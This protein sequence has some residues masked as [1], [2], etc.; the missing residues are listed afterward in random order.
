MATDLSEVTID[1]PDGST[2]V[3]KGNIVVQSKQSPAWLVSGVGQSLN[4]VRRFVDGGGQ[5]GRADS[6][7]QGLYF[8]TGGGVRVHEIGFDQWEGN[9]D[10]WGD[11]SASDGPV[12]KL[13]ELDHK[14]ASVRIDSTRPAT[15]SFAEF[16]PTGR[17]DPLS[18]VPDDVS[19]IFDGQE[20]ASSFRTSVQLA[21]SMDLRETIEQAG[22]AANDFVLN[23][24]IDGAKAA[25][26]LP[27]P[28][29]ATDQL[30]FEQ[31]RRTVDA[32]VVNDGLP[33]SLP[34]A[35]EPGERL[36]T[37]VYRGD[38]ASELEGLLRQGVLEKDGAD[39]VVLEAVGNSFTEFTDEYVLKGGSVERVHPATDKAFQVALRLG[40]YEDPRP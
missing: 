26:D 16:S 30:S 1:L 2:F 15:L 24:V 4:I 23:P 31:L 13:C 6:L 32:G 27:L 8:G 39:R 29:D 18:V 36:L 20:R 35:L 9:T 10:T 21:E 22:R 37:T 11:A 3:A 33:S 19:L 34:V 17:Y 12:S 38:K 25:L 5:D 28:L 14:L 40:Q 7:R